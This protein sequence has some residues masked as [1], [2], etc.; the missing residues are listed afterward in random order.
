[1]KKKHELL[2]I[3]NKLTDG[4]VANNI[5]WSTVEETRNKNNYL[6][7]RLIREDKSVDTAACRPRTYSLQESYDLLRSSYD[8]LYDDDGDETVSVETGNYTGH[9]DT[10]LKAQTDSVSGAI[11]GVD[12]PVNQSFT[13]SSNFVDETAM[14]AG[15]TAATDSDIEEPFSLEDGA[16]LYTPDVWK[17]YY[18]HLQKI[19]SSLKGREG[20]P[21]F[22]AVFMISA[23]DGDGVSDIKVNCL[24]FHVL[25][26]LLLL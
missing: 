15:C 22:S 23:V 26:L 16:D 9:D 17:S 5:S 12:S 2:D 7:D 4:I 21:N 1:M 13:S 10:L 8:E 18:D 14:M 20:W 24:F 19:A 11:D 25:L 6:V 3:V